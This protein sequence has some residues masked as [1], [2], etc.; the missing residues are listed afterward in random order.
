M[1]VI[2][3]YDM[4]NLGSIKNMLHRIGCDE[5]VISRD[6]NDIIRADKLILPGVGA[7]DQGVN[8]LI[9]FDLFDTIKKAV[10]EDG[11]IIMGICLGMQLLGRR[12]E[13]G[14]ETGLN[15]IPFDSIRFRLGNDYKIPHMGWSDIEIE[16]DD[17]ITDNMH[18]VEQRF[19]FVHSYHAQCD[20]ES[21]VL[22]NCEY[23]YKF[24]AAV[25]CDN[26]YGFQFHPEKSHKYGMEL[27]KNFVRI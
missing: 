11:K 9:R 16:K 26:V 15:L 18:N 5:V 23:G 1:I 8:N 25:S 12:S 24:A 10:V 22:M 27:L 17:P 19:Y 21:D 2:I 4:G 13:E 3:D 7:F 6:H 14:V 20:N